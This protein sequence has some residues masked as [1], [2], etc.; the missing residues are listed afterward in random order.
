MKPVL[1]LL[2][3]SWLTTNIA[4]AQKSS[5]DSLAVT[6]LLKNK[7]VIVDSV[8]IIF[9]RY[10]L[11]GA[12][13]IKQ[14]FYPTD[15]KVVIEKVPKGKYYVDIYCIGIDQQ[16]YTRVSTIGKRKTNKVTVPLQYYEAYIPGTAII[17]PSIIDLNNL[18]VTQKKSYK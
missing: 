1:L 13:V 6:I 7:Y 2:L 14:K 4:S 18:I 11:T 17:P 10:D 12:G 5:P 15:N 8:Y 3:C 9:D 16:N